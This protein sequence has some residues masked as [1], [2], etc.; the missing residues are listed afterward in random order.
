MII[1]LIIIALIIIIVSII[2]CKDTINF[3]YMQIFMRKNKKQPAKLRA[4]FLIGLAGH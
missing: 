2:R 4:V 1:I 3:A